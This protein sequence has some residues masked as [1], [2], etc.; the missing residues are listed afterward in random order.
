VLPGRAVAGSKSRHDALEVDMTRQPGTVHRLA[1][2]LHTQPIGTIFTKADLR[3][4]LGG[5][6]DENL[7]RRMRDLR[8]F[9]WQI[10]TYR[11]DSA[12]QPTQHRLRAYGSVPRATP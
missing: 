10:D 11:E 4:A 8:K 7:G 6:Q 3:R 9:G 2:Y 5:N 12:L 1:V